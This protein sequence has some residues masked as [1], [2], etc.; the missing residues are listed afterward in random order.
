MTFTNTYNKEYLTAD[1]AYAMYF[2]MGSVAKNQS[3]II[4]TNYGVFSNESVDYSA[5]AALNV[6]APDV[7]ELTSDKTA[8]KDDGYFTT[9][10]AI[11]N[12]SKKTFDR[13]RV[14]VY[15]TGGITALDQNGTDAGATYDDPY[16]MEFTNFVPDQRQ[17]IEWKFK[18]KPLEE[19]SYS[20]ISYKIYNVSDDAT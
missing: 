17:T 8:Y 10:T 3:S 9:T 7:M 20:K 2:D 1:S 6:I 18:A 14:V 16:Y 5:S 12:V 13:V 19:G 15:T 11:E 4:A